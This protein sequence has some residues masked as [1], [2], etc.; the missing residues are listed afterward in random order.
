ML[1]VCAKEIS[2]GYNTN[3]ENILEKLSIEY[4]NPGIIILFHDFYSSGEKIL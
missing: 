4:Q 3:P 1:F 2:F